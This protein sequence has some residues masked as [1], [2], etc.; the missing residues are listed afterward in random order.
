MNQPTEILD[1]RDTDATTPCFKGFRLL[2]GHELPRAGDFFG[3]QQGLQP[4]EGPTG[5]RA[6]AFV[7]PIYRPDK[8]PSRHFGRAF[9]SVPVRTF[10][11]QL[12]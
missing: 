6:D 11:S 12:G 4:W 1:T 10:N 3:G 8:K 7:K 2:K 5:F 9:F